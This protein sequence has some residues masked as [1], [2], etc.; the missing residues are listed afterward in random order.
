MKNRIFLILFFLFVPL[1]MFGFQPGQGGGNPGQGGGPGGGGGNDPCAGPNP[2]PNCPAVPIDK[3]IWILLIG[4][5][6]AGGYFVQK[7]VKKADPP[8]VVE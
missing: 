3:D 7:R 1:I 8:S 4:G 2:P 6:L 5:A